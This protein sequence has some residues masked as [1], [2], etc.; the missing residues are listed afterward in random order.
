LDE[1]D[2][3]LAD[4]EPI[5]DFLFEDEVLDEPEEPE[6]TAENANQQSTPEAYDQWLTAKALLERGGPAEM[7]TVI[8]RKWDQ[9][10]I[11]IGRAHSNPLLD[12]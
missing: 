2:P 6:A 1:I 8:G 5:P 12:T 10:G 9:D 11:P 4:Q 7:A 3:I